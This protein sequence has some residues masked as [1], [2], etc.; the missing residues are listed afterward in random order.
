MRFYIEQGQ[1]L[2][3]AKRLTDYREGEFRFRIGYYRVVFDVK[4][5]T[6]Y[7]IKIDKR[8]QAYD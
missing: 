7:I 8:D 3:F 2:K 5:N 6:I 1:P 4:D